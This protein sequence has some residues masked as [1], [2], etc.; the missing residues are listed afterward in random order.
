M[1]KI[2]ALPLNLHDHNTYDGDVHIQYERLSESFRRKHCYWKLRYGESLETQRKNSVEHDQKVLNE[3][4]PFQTMYN[5]LFDESLKNKDQVFAT[6]I[7]LNG[8]NL[9]GRDRY[10]NNLNNLGRGNFGLETEHFRPRHLWDFTVLDN[11]YYADHHQCHAAHTFLM[12]G[13]EESDILVIDGGG[14]MFRCIFI[15]SDTKEIFDLSDELPIGWMWNV[16]TRLAGFGVLQEGK[17]MG[18]AGFGKYSARWDSIFEL[19]MDEFWDRGGKYW[20]KEEYFDAFTKDENWKA[21]MAF[22][23]QD[24]TNKR[25]MRIISQLKTSDN[26]CVAGGVSYNG[27][28]NEEFT[29]LWTNVHVPN[30]PGDEG[31]AIGLYMHCNYVINGEKHYPEVYAGKRY[32]INESELFEGLDEW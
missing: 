31:Q 2:F 32:Q 7:T 8:V 22:T 3:Q 23:L 9:Y 25:V 30:C 21:D 12:S 15:P 13:Y 18:L 10:V 28:L 26:L 17:L 5:N 20:P 11:V 4:I 24:F 16:M 29:K 6:N 14:Q 27:Y 1:K 19:M